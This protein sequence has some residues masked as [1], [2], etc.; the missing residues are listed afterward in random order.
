MQ[1]SFVFASSTHCFDV[2]AKVSRCRSAQ[3]GEQQT[4][5]EAV[6]TSNGHS[7]K[8]V[9]SVHVA[10]TSRC[11]DRSWQR[12]NRHEKMLSRDSHM[13]VVTANTHRKAAVAAAEK[14]QSIP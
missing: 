3:S 2:F 4:G 7:C 13:C 14:K 10:V 5:A 6:C 1:V 9:L 8:Y 11:T 12:H